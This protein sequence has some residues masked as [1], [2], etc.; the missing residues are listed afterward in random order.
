MRPLSKTSKNPPPKTPKGQ[1]SLGSNMGTLRIRLPRTI[2]INRATIPLGLQDTP[3]NRVLGDRILRQLQLDIDNNTFQWADRH[4]YRQLAQPHQLNTIAPPKAI[5]LW[6]RYTESRQPYLETSTLLKDYKAITTRLLTAKITD[7]ATAKLKLL[8]VP[9][10][11]EVVKRTLAQLQAMAKWAAKQNLI[12]DLP[13][14]LEALDHTEIRKTKG[15][16]GKTRRAFTKQEQL[17]I[18]EAFQSDRFSPKHAHSHYYNYLYFLFNFGCRPSEA[19]GIQWQD[20]DLKQE[21]IIFQRSYSAV[22]RQ[23]KSIKTH[24]SRTFP[25][26]GSRLEWLQSIQL[27]Q[28]QPTDLVFPSPT[29]LPITHPNFLRNVWQP[30]LKNLVSLGE[31]ESYLPPNNTRHTFITQAIAAGMDDEDVAHICG[32]SDRTIRNHYKAKKRQIQVKDF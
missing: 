18:L 5:D 15:S 10:S 25:L 26:A 20:I 22:T 11:L 32:N 21:Q 6:S 12:T 17:T 1:A 30:I 31:I 24:T 29:G 23:E 4:N 14:T 7:L 13:A 27:S 3:A 28:F 16:Q 2:S 9:Y 19:V 8:Q